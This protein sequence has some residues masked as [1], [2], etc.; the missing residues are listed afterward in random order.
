MFLCGFD[1]LLGQSEL[2]RDSKR[3]ALA[4]DTNQEPVGGTEC[5]DVKLAAGVLHI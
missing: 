4:G 3:I 5:L 1:D 2:G